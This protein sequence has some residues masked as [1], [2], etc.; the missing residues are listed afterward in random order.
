MRA[1]ILAPLLALAAWPAA[2]ETTLRVMSFNA[3]GGGANEGKG[4]EETVAAI[5]RPGR[6]SSACRRPGSSPTPAR[7]PTA[8]QPAQR[9]PRHRPGPGLARL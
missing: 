5:G 6:T 3:W 1:L 9:R 7:P 8:W 2:A 4:I